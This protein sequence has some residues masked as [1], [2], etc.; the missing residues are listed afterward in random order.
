MW[1]LAVFSVTWGYDVVRWRQ[2]VIECCK[3]LLKW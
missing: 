3:V 2:L 1:S